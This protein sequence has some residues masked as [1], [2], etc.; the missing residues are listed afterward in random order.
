MKSNRTTMRRGFTLVELLVTIA[1]IAVLATLGFMGSKSFLKKAAAVKDATNMRSLWTSVSLYAADNSDRLPGPIN[2][3]QKALYG[4]AS[5]GRI[6][7]YL[8]PYLGYEN[9]KP[10]DFLDAMASS[11]QKTP[12][13]KAA[14]C[15]FI[16]SDVPLNQDPA[17]ATFQPW[18]YPGK[19]KP[20]T[21]SAA[22]SR[23]DPSR[24][25]AITDVD[26]L[27]PDAAGAGWIND[28]PDGM[29]HGTYRLAMY[30]DGSGGKVNVNNKP[31]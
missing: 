21:M 7:F 11:W 1:I 19:S 6:S 18:G 31:L 27:H 4:L 9:P 13:T 3:G 15:Y 22:L 8:A 12:A 2:S 17:A 26:Q 25:W 23:I 30:F 10:N 20:M 14:P 5:T 28:V 24:T 29:A 16:R